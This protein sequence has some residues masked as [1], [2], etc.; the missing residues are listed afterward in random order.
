[1]RLIWSFDI[2][3]QLMSSAA[4]VDGTVY[5]I[6]FVLNLLPG[7]IDDIRAVEE[8]DSDGAEGEK[9]HVYGIQSLPF[10][11]RFGNW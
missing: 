3:I 1:M 2:W 8:V 10:T 11:V 5:W 6:V 4:V 9:L 7:N